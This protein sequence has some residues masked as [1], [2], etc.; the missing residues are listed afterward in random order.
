MHKW[1]I[2]DEFDAVSKA[3]AEFLAKEIEA[4]L[5]NKNICHVILPG[6]NTPATC[7][8]Y[9]AN[10]KLPWEKIHWYLGDERCFPRGHA[11]RNDVMLD[12][13]FWSLLSI[14]NIHLIPAELGAEKAAEHYR[15]EI[16]TV[17]HFDIAFL[18]IGEDGHTA[19]LFPENQAL[20]DSR[21]V[22]P[23]YHSPKPPSDR[24]SLSLQTLRNAHCKVVL[25]SG[26]SKASIIERIKN[27]ES[28]PINCIGDINWFIDQDALSLV[29]I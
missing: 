7:L 2:Y 1:F 20:G 4:C 12:K 10:K 5:R 29:T 26:L 13:N 25:A 27:G 21:S 11:D 22:I 17:D 16:A 6:G 3:A 28:F 9:L 19:S 24:V 15:E 18:G 14:T 8:R 23:V